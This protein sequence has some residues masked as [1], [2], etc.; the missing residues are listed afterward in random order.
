V[1]SGDIG[2]D[3]GSLH[4]QLFAGQGIGLSGIAMWTTDTG[5]GRGSTRRRRHWTLHRATVHVAPHTATSTATPAR[6]G[7]YGWGGNATDPMFM[8]L[9]VRW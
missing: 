6:A 8:E 2:S 3:F 4:N 7:G 5:E 9:I 1:W